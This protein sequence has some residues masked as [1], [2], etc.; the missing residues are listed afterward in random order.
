MVGSSMGG[1]LML[2]SGQDAARQSLSRCRPPFGE[3][4]RAEIFAGEFGD[5]W[6]AAPV[7]RL[8]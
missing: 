8:D 7:Q 1:V 2:L 4:A 3:V 6:G 5:E